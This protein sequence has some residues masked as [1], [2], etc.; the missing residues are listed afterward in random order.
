MEGTPARSGSGF[1]DPLRS[2]FLEAVRNRADVLAGQI[3]QEGIVA[4][5]GKIPPQLGDQINSSGLGNKVR[6]ALFFGNEAQDYAITHPPTPVRSLAPFLVAEAQAQSTTF[7]DIKDRKN[8]FIV[9]EWDPTNNGITADNT[10]SLFGCPSKNSSDYYYGGE[11]K[12]QELIRIRTQLGGIVTIHYVM[13]GYNRIAD[14]RYETGPFTMAITVKRELAE[15]IIK[16]VTG[17]EAK[18]W[19]PMAIEYIFQH[20]FGDLVGN[21]P[22]AK[23]VRFKADTLAVYEKLEDLDKGNCRNI[24]FGEPVGEA[25]PT[26]EAIAELDKKAGLA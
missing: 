3:K 12:R 16:L 20:F 10:Y 5:R 9:H 7:G 25:D 2:Q 18:P 6:K 24:S 4:F 21:D 11:R 14:S 19:S 13:N 8:F 23:V 26:P 1:Q 15:E 17:E 22:I